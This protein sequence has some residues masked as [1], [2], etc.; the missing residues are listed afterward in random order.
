MYKRQEND[1][2]STANDYMWDKLHEV[3]QRLLDQQWT[4]INRGLVPPPLLLKRTGE[5][6]DRL[7]ELEE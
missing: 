3:L 1:T 7:K 2:I 6:E 4:F 5:V